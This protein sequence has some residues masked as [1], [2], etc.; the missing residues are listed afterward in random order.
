MLDA[1]L[2]LATLPTMQQLAP[3]LSDV[4]LMRF[5]VLGLV[6]PCARGAL[7]FVCAG[8][9]ATGVSAT[10][11]AALFDAYGCEWQ[12][13]VRARAHVRVHVRACMLSV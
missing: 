8:E 9:S 7:T 3:A 5:S 11:P 1:L 12:V 13:C 2:K 10:A 4:H 6:V